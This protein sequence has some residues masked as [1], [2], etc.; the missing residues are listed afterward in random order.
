MRL[1][2]STE[3]VVRRCKEFDRRRPTRWPAV[4]FDVQLLYAQQSDD[5]GGQNGKKR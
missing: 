4:A 5:R 3:V 1:A 2:K